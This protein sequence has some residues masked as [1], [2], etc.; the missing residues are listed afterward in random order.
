MTYP[1]KATGKQIG[2]EG[3][4]ERILGGPEFVT[5]RRDEAVVTRSA[6]SSYWI[7]EKP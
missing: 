4:D 6:G 3:T 1:D 2:Q 5:E 7:P